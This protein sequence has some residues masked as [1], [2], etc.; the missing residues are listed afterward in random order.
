M[1]L[2]LC[3]PNRRIEAELIKPK[4]YAVVIGR[5]RLC[6]ARAAARLCRGRRARRRGGAAAAEG[7]PLL[8][9]SRFA[10]L[11]DRDAT[12]R[13]VIDALEWLD[14][15]VTSRDVG[16]GDDRRATAHRR[17]R[18][19][20]VPAGRRAMAHLGGDAVSQ[21]DICAGRSPRSPARRSCSSTPVTPTPRRPRPT[22]RATS[23]DWPGG[24]DVIRFVN[25]L[26]KTENG[27][28]HLRVVAGDASFAAE[29]AELGPRRLQPGADRG[30]RPARPTCCTR[31]RSPSPRSTT[32]SPNA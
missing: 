3:G 17:E 7:R 4:L 29:R 12:R 6:R 24:V 25:D 18:R 5:E 31:A 13:A 21:F 14:A 22:R 32:T 23:A 27:L 30:P 11:V 16:D 2:S 10:P 28:D 15:Q 26:A 19:L 9:T 1:R 20:L 8:A